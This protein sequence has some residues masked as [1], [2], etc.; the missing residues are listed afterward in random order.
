LF[1]QKKDFSAALVQVKALDK[2]QKGDGYK[3]LL[4]AENC[5]DNGNFAVARQA[6][7]YVINQGNQNPNYHFAISALLNLR[8]REV[9]VEKHAV[10]DFSQIDSEYRKGLAEIGWNNTALKTI[11]EYAE[12]KAY[13][14]NDAVGAVQLLDSC[15]QIQ[16]LTQLEKAAVKM[17]LADILVLQNDVWQA[18]LYYMQIDKDF[19]FEAIGSEAKFKNARIYYYEGDFKFAQSQLDVLKQSTSKLIANDAL[20]LS[21]LITDNLGLDSNYTAMYQFAQADL[22]LQQHQFERAFQ[23]FDSINAE[24]PTHSLSDD[25]LLRK[26]EAY[27]YQGKWNEAIA[28]Y[29]KILSVYAD[30]ILADN[31]VFKLAEIYEY[32]LNDTSKALEYYKKILFDFKGSVLSESAR[33][34][35][36]QLRGDG[37]E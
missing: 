19:K 3:V 13:Y 17:K 25:I 12:I 20:D 5:V 28:M 8:Y 29:S 2:R 30:D 15:M 6:V 36:R 35:V 7:Q 27:E 34:K 22:L 1:I 9:V 33:K 14:G 26:G 4:L 16:G 23:L 10:A 24:F 11:L 37:I 31:A 32:R 18:S 21:V